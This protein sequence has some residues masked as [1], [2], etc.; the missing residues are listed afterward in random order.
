MPGTKMLES[1]RM[2]RRQCVAIV[3]FVGDATGRPASPHNG[4]CMKSRKGYI[5]RYPHFLP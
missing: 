2:A 4:L 5:L 1:L 3:G